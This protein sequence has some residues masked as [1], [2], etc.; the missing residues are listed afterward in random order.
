MATTHLLARYAMPET[1]RRFIKRY[2][3]VALNL[4]QS[5][6]LQAAEWVA[7]DQIDLSIAAGP[8]TPVPGVALLP[9]PSSRIRPP[10]GLFSLGRMAV[11][12]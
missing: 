8:P 4:R 9:S 2:P 5:T 6:P 11:S 3:K 1:G 7:S 10:L 12:I